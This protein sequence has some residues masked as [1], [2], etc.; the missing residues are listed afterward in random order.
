MAVRLDLI[1]E[2]SLARLFGAQERGRGFGR[3]KRAVEVPRTD[4][5]VATGRVSGR[6]PQLV[7]YVGQKESSKAR[8]G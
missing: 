6:K 1:S 8:T 5:T 4:D 2:G 3:G 7:V